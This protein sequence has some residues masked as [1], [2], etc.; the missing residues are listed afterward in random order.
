MLDQCGVCG[1]NGTSCTNCT[2]LNTNTLRARLDGQ[3]LQQ[4]NLLLRLVSYI[5]KTSQNMPRIRKLRQAASDIY[6]TTWKNVW[7]TL[8]ETAQ[9]CTAQP[10][11]TTISIQGQLSTLSGNF[12]SFLTQS[13]KANVL[14]PSSPARKRKLADKIMGIQTELTKRNLNL[15]S[16]FPVS[17][18]TCN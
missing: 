13:K 14:V 2:Q 16:S 18:T 7:I 11:C 9:S 12:S 15:V 6:T 8:P 3:A 1:G 17:N 10:F 5:P 4:R